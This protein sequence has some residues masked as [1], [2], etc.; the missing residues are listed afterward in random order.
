[1][2]VAKARGAALKL[3]G[4][5]ANG[6]DPTAVET[7]AITFAALVARYIEHAKQHGKKTWAQDESALKLYE[8]K[9]WSS[10]CPTFPA[11]K[12]LSSTTTSAR[13][14]ATRDAR[15]QSVALVQIVLMK[16]LECRFRAMRRDTFEIAPAQTPDSA[17]IV[18]LA[19]KTEA[20][21]WQQRKLGDRTRRKQGDG[22]PLAAGVLAS[23]TRAKRSPPTSGESHKF[24]IT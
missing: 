13:S 12:S 1:M 11:T 19:P 14:T 16:C 20:A 10:R 22:C 21:E 17:I 8:P 15:Q 9:G 6:V 7:E 24:P 18:S 2:S 3:K 4:D 5:I 23:R